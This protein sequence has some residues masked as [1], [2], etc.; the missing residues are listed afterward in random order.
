MA[1]VRFTFVIRSYFTRIYWSSIR[2]FSRSPSTPVFRFAFFVVFVG[3]MEAGFVRVSSCRTGRANDKRQSLFVFRVRIR[4]RVI[5]SS[6]LGPV[7]VIKSFA[8]LLFV[9]FVFVSHVIGHV[10]S[11]VEVRLPISSIIVVTSRSSVAP[12]IVVIVSLIP[13]SVAL[14]RS[15]ET[16]TRVR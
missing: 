8:F 12:A 4:F 3:P 13:V 15:F 2:G 11:F 16:R 5:F 10:D 6:P 14:A 9:S 7:I 1:F